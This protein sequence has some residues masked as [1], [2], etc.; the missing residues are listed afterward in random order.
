MG[1]KI[2]AEFK[3]LIQQKISPYKRQINSDSIEYKFLNG[4]TLD[5]SNAIGCSKLKSHESLVNKLNDPETAPE[6]YWTIFKTLVNGGKIPLIPQLLVGIKLVT[7]FLEKANLINNTYLTVY[8][9]ILKQH[10]S[11]KY[12]L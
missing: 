2:N 6:R 10:C 12:K 7:D 8:S 1:I 11:C 5:I 4:L 9:Y 3:S